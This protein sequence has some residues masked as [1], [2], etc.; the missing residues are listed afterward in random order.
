MEETGSE[1]GV[2]TANEQQN[3]KSTLALLTLGPVLSSPLLNKG[4]GDSNVPGTILR[5]SHALN[6]HNHPM[7]SV[8]LLLP[9]YR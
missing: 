9:F 2:K 7:E 1:K 8:L 5:A 4:M 6:P 3:W